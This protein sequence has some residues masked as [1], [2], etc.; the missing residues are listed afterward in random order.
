MIPSEKNA[1]SVCL[2]VLIANMV[3][4]C[5]ASTSGW[6]Q[7]FNPLDGTSSQQSAVEQELIEACCVLLDI[8]DVHTVSPQ[9]STDC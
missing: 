3:I 5:L 7:V 4:A 8:G 9:A 2:L 6:F 1:H